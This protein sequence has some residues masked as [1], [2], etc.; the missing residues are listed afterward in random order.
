MKLKIVLWVVGV[1]FGLGLLGNIISFSH[2]AVAGIN[3]SVTPTIEV[4]ATIIPTN[5]QIPSAT[6]ILTKPTHTPTP[7]QKPVYFAP[8]AAPTS[9]PAVTESNG[10]SNDNYHT[11]SDGNQVHAPAYSNSVPA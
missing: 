1:I 9:V 3:T 2:A 5:A 4:R 10:L 11:N 7:T 6:I 8:T